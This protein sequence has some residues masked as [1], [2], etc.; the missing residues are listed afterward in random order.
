MNVTLEMVTGFVGL[1]GLFAVVTTMFINRFGRVDD[2]VSKVEEALAAH[3]V[4]SAE[5]YVTMAALTTFEERLARTEERVLAETRSLRSDLA[6]VL[7]RP[8]RTRSAKPLE[9]DE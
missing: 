1:L 5:S 4:K 2:R 3:K 7:S 9:V 8:V 6:Q